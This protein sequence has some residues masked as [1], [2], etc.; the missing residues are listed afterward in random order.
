MIE[1]NQAEF[2]SLSLLVGNHQLAFIG[3]RI[4]I[5]G[6]KYKLPSFKAIRIDIR[7]P[8]LPTAGGPNA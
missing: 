3:L 5:R 8:F 4:V 6:I 1:N 2:S 7:L